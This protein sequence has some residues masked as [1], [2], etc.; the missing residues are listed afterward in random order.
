[1]YWPNA[2]HLHNCTCYIGHGCLHVIYSLFGFI[3]NLFV[4]LELLLFFFFFCDN[5][6]YI[7]VVH[8][9]S[10]TKHVIIHHIMYTYYLLV[11]QL[12]YLRAR[13]IYAWASLSARV[14]S[15]EGE[16]VFFLVFTMV[17]G[18]ESLL[19]PTLSVICGGFDF[20]PRFSVF[21]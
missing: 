7:A 14:H 17:V 10:I 20:F 9:T 5:I 6:I 18:F 2:W 12:L 15:T 8:F 16:N 1:M 13:T 19:N 4:F 11:L 21:G 3:F